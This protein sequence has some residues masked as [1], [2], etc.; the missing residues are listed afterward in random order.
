MCDAVSAVIVAAIIALPCS[1]F[2]YFDH[3]EN[4]ARIAKGLPPEEEDDL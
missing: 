4:M 3:R 2:L 1:L